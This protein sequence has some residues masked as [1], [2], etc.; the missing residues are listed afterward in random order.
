M[1]LHQTKSPARPGFLF[2][3]GV[4]RFSTRGLVK[5]KMS[6]E[7]QP[8]L[9]AALESHDPRQKSF[10]RRFSVLFLCFLITIFNAS[11]IA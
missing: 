11:T 1:M 9:A 2:G 6:H 8:A 3:A 10:M 4:H 5:I 7:P